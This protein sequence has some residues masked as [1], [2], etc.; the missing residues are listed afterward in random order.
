MSRKVLLARV[1]AVAALVAGAV[2]VG[3]SPAYAASVTATFAKTSSW[4]SGY[5]GQFSI[6]NETSTAITSWQVE[7]DLPSGTSVGAYWDALQTNSN[8]H[9]V[10]KNRDYNASVA[11]GATVTFGFNGTGTAAPVNCKIN[12]A[13]CAGPP[14]TTTSPNPT[15]TNDNSTTATSPTT[16][17]TTTSR[18]TTTT[19]T[20]TTSTDPGDGTAPRKVL[21]GYLHA[22][23]AN[24]SGY[25]KM[26]D[27]SDDWDFID[28]A[29][30]EPT[31][32]TSGELK[33]NLCPV[34]ECPN[35]D[36]E[37]EFIAGIKAKQAQGKKVLISIGGQN[38]QVQ[39]TTTAARDAFVRSVGGI[40][41]R[42]GLDG[43]DV[44]FEGH[45]LSLN[46]NDT[47]FRAPTTPVIVNL[48][49]ALKTL[50]AKYG[51]KFQLT[52]APETFFVQVGYQ[53]YAG[54]GGADPRAGAYLPV[55][56][57]LRDDLT[58]L[59]VQHYNSGPIMGLDNQYH[60]M[61]GADFHVAMADMVLQ[62]FPVRGDA[63]K[64]FPG[65]RPEQVAIGL[66][67][68]I[69]AGNG[70]TSVA[71]TQTAFKCVSLGTNCG[72]YKPKATYPNLRGLMTWSINWDK[73]NNFE[74]S[75]AHRA[76]LPR[77]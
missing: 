18:T 56:H 1:A 52:M 69:N 28:L 16:S 70:F 26:K 36:T 47:D 63:T 42:F 35:V 33:F 54:N 65:L 4:S 40:I 43:L 37:A 31:S 14:I 55:I 68:S 38:G 57:A 46:A 51:A 48:I 44:D 60:T 15:T 73:Y 17:T 3:F 8:G 21:V 71:D 74:F 24:G 7:F 30:A 39:L 19:T 12:G 59:H 76:F 29:F 11:P 27:V 2:V 6:K 66:P 45:S 13:S 34:A 22:S 72:S 32:V 75:K 58:L 9:Y 50:K 20:T 10:F 62:G 41:D 64:F 5:T 23:F 49:S 53:F 61:G 25:I 67:A 77:K